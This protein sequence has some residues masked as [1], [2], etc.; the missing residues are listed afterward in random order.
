[1]KLM[2]AHALALLAYSTDPLTECSE[3]RVLQQRSV[4]FLSSHLESGVLSARADSLSPAL[5]TLENI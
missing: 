4:E 1:M 2:R 5:R 3:E